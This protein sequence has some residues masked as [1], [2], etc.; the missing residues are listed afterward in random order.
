[1]LLEHGADPNISS[2]SG[3]PLFYASQ[4]MLEEILRT[5]LS[6]SSINPE[7][8]DFCG[9]NGLDLIADYKPMAEKKAFAMV[10]H[11]P[12]LS[13]T[14]RTHLLKCL[15]E[16]IDM[17]VSADIE[18]LRSLSFRLGQQLLLLGDETSARIALE[19]E[20]S[21]ESKSGEPFFPDFDCIQCFTDKGHLFFCKTCPM[22]ELCPKCL[23]DRKPDKAPWCEG[24]EFLQIPGDEW[25]DLRE[26]V[27]NIQGQSFEEWL[28]T[29]QTRYCK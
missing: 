14:R 16:K 9:R 3:P 5:L 19:F 4:Y 27:V 18:D 13:S 12:T 21:E 11:K 20:V 2:L 23:A 17:M 22:V 29:L 15:Q 8:L 25:K 24:H 28:K 1:M 10:D 26:G 6:R 7:V